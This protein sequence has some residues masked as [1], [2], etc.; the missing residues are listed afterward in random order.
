MPVGYLLSRATLPRLT[1]RAVQLCVV[2]Q[3][4]FR[5]SLGNPL[6]YCGDSSTVVAFQIL[7]ARR[8]FTYARTPPEP[9]PEFV[10]DSCIHWSTVNASVAYQFSIED[11]NGPHPR[12]CLALC[13][14]VNQKYALLNDD[15]CLC[16]NMPL[17][18]VLDGVSVLGNNNCD[19]QCKGNFFYLC[20]NQRN[21]TV[22]SMYINQPKCRH[23]KFH[24]WS[25]LDP[26]EIDARDSFKV[27]KWPRT[28]GNV[29]I[30][31]YR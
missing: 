22:Y 14:Q 23:G 24:W 15:R 12:H 2:R 13:S 30:A 25:V 6:E 19:Q 4:S 17:K 16:T 7:D 11:S 18:S 21:R 29:S 28:I 8:T 1:Y 9:F 10:H 31:I 3:H 27:S 5:L 26:N 20:G